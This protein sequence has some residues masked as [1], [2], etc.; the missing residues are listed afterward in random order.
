MVR[1]DG[2]VFL[3]PDANANLKKVSR[4]MKALRAQGIE[5][6]VIGNGAWSGIDPYS[7]EQILRERPLSNPVAT[8]RC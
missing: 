1:D 2:S 6:G 5:Y 4:V 7:L 3:R 8:I